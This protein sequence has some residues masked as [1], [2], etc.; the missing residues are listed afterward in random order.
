MQDFFGYAESNQLNITAEMEKCQN[1]CILSY[2]T[3]NPDLSG[4]GVGAFHFRRV[5]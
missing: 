3:G 5:I 4:I 1:P 2:G